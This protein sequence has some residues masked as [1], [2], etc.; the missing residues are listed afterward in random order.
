MLARLAVARGLAFDGSEDTA[1]E[2]QFKPRVEKTPEEKSG[3]QGRQGR[4][5]YNA[6]GDRYIY[7]L[8]LETF[9]LCKAAD[10]H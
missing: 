10:I 2:Q 8:I 9:T 5:R 3:R 7:I 4:Q 6:L 1:G